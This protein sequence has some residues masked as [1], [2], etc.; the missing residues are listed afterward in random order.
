MTSPL[1]LVLLV[2]VKL[3]LR[4]RLLWMRLSAKKFAEFY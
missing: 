2:P 1:V 4:S 3:T